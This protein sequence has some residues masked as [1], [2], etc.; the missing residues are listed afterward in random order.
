MRLLL[1]SGS[2]YEERI[3]EC[4][5]KIGYTP[6]KTNVLKPKE[7]ICKV[8]VRNSKEQH[9]QVLCLASFG[10][11]KYRIVKQYGK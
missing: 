9:V 3:K 10:G 4:E 1:V 11:C 5:G 6:C 8:M 7:E 2:V